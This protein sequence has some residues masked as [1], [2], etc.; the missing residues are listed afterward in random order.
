[1]SR[2]DLVNTVGPSSNVK[3]NE[4]G[5]VHLMNST[6][7]GTT[8]GTFDSMMKGR[9][10]VEHWDLHPRV[11][12]QCHVLFPQKFQF[13]QHEPVIHVSPSFPQ[14]PSKGII[15]AETIG[16]NRTLKYFIITELMVTMIFYLSTE[17]TELTD[18]D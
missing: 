12:E 6:P 3:T 18:V 16:S 11:F 7:Y 8:D 14:R 4:F 9:S 1:M 2:I 10:H 15:A 17:L 13:E 5:F